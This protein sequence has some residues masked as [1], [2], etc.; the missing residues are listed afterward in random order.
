MGADS[1][2]H[3][4][5][6]V[7]ARWGSDGVVRV[8]LNRPE[9]R[10]AFDERMIAEL[11]DHFGTIAASDPAAVRLVVIEGAGPVFCAGADVGWMGRAGR[12]GWDDNVADAERMA[13]MLEAIDACPVPVIARVH[14]AAL[15][16]GAGICAVADRVVAERGTRFGFTEVRVGIV[17]AVIGP[18]VLRKIGETHAR[19][20]FLVG[21]R[22][23]AAEAHRM[24]LVHEVADGTEDLDRRVEALV[25]EALLAA[26]GAARVAKRTIRELR[27]RD[28]AASRALTTETI[29]RQR[30]T[31]EARAG[32]EALL[33][34]R[35]P[36]WQPSVTDD[37]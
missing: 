17:P 31:D 6:A 15:G 33:A 10:N 8:A 1:G 16:G 13:A 11:T 21:D 24:G 23:D 19:A 9:R 26:P 3:G 18:F 34:R 29:A 14:G 7:S 28:A 32:F 27:G 22:F 30:G 20:T 35:P 2:E 36:P 37:A 25:A 12:L 5:G 4:S